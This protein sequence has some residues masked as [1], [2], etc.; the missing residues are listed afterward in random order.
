VKMAFDFL[1]KKDGV[2]DVGQEE[3]FDEKKA[4]KENAG[5]S[6][7]KK[8][9]KSNLDKPVG[10]FYG[11]ED[12][13]G[14]EKPVKSTGLKPSSGSKSLDSE[15][16]KLEFNKINAKIE[17]MNSL[18]KGFSERFSNVSQQIGEIRT[19]NL[20]NEKTISKMSLEGRKAADIVKEVKP[21]KLRLDYQKAG[22][23]IQTL[24]EKIDANKQFQETLMKEV[25]DL[26]RKAGIFIGTDALLKL[27]EDVKKDLIELQRMGSRVRV[28]ADKSEQLFVELRKGFAES[29]KVDEIVSSLDASYSGLKEEVGRL[30]IDYGNIVDSDNFEDFKKSMRNKFIALESSIAEFESLKEN[31]QRL[32]HLIEKILMIAKRNEEDIADVAATIGDDKVKRIS[33]Y[34]NQLNS[35]LK[36][37]DTLAGQ[38]GA[39]RKKLGLS[40]EKIS[41]DPVKSK[42]VKK[43]KLKL[44]NMEV[45][46]DVSKGLV[47]EKPR[48]VKKP[49]KRQGVSEIA[50]VSKEVEK[51]KNEV[52]EKAKSSVKRKNLIKESAVRKKDESHV[53]NVKEGDAFKDIQ[54]KVKESSDFS[55]KLKEGFE[56]NVG[57]FVGGVKK[58]REGVGKKVGG[59]LKKFGK[60]DSSEGG[61]GEVGGKEMKESADAG[62]GGGEENTE[63]KKD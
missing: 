28:N 41:V 21:E 26:R 47:V 7:K 34:E 37:I 24:A 60:K 56:E 48:V 13:G 2:P 54:G 10:E 22:L 23:K 58:I 5:K 25:K 57:G 29:R 52:D 9:E 36:I 20:S 1:K 32:S 43:D 49:V 17:A 42:I 38:V 46:P 50:E 12:D 11:V 51:L 33:D 53:E 27:N 18:L 62:S 19:M 30:K 6:I 39:I 14:P 31:N 15:K 59:I 40:K 61:E 45:H 16:N 4:K 63:K 8:S 44:K 3:T 55:D 35:V